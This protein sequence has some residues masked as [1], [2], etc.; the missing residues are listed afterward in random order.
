MTRT[1]T[2]T[3]RSNGSAASGR[4]FT[5]LEAVLGLALL[6]ILG[7]A[8]FG[9]LGYAWRIEIEARQTLAAAEIANRVLIS[10]IDDPTSPE[11][12]PETIAYE[13][14]DYR[15]SI[16]VQP[17][18]I[19]DAFPD[20]RTSRDGLPATQEALESLELVTVTAWLDDDTSASAA[21]GRTP[22][23]RME[24]VINPFQYRGN[25]TLERLLQSPERQNRLL[26]Q[27]SGIDGGGS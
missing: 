18:I 5:F 19:R 9:V 7:G 4:G 26:M 13:Q 12:L 14:A 17:T 3:R 6:G 21:P 11:K 22:T 20:A 27:M 10:Y 23:F 24:R 8:I 1:P 25:D 15:W 16:D 2:T